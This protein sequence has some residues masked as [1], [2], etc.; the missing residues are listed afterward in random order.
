MAEH[1]IVEDYDHYQQRQE[2][3][4]NIQRIIILIVFGYVLPILLI[5]GVL[6]GGLKPTTSIIWFLLW[7]GISIY[8][9]YLIKKRR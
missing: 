8:I 1:I 7:L 2:K 4:R 3:Q 6:F 5:M 9:T